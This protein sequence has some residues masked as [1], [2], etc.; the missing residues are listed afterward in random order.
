MG[1]SPAKWIKTVLFGKKSSKPNISKGRE[2]ISNE[3]EVVV[4]ARAA[5]TEFV[6]DPPA[7]FHESTNTTDYNKGL[8]L[9]NKEAPSVLGNGEP[10][11]QSTDSQGSTP[12]N[13]AYDPEKIRQEQAATKAQAAFRGYLARRAFWA[14]KGIIRLQALIRGHLVRRQ[15]V[16]TLCSML[17]I[18]KL[19]ALS[20]GRQVRQSI[21]GLE[22]Q[23]RCHVTPLE[24][25]LVDPVRVNI[26][27][28]MA[29]L[30]VNVFISKLLAFSPT[31]MPLRLHYEPG[32]P[33]SVP[34]WLERWSATHFW[35]PLPQPR[36]VPD[37]KSQRTH[38]DPQTGRVKRSTR[39]LPAANV[40]SVSVQVTS[41][42]EK[43][44]RILRKVSSQPADPVQENPQIELEKVKRNLRKVHTPIVENSVQTEIEAQNLTQNLEKASSSV[45]GHNV[46][47]GIT[48][49][50]VEKMKNEPIVALFNLPDAEITPEPSAAKEVFNLLSDDQVAMD[51]KTLTEGTGEEINTPSDEAAVES[52]ILTESSKKDENIPVPNVVL[53]QGEDLT[54]NDNQKSSRKTS[55]PAKQER[56]ENGL[57]NSPTLPSYMAATESAK[58]KLR[59]QGSPRLG[60][61]A[62]EK[63]EKT[64]STRRHSLPSSA[65]GKITSQS[66]RTQKP[67]Q[68]GGKGGIKSDKS[69]SASRD[70]KASQA[71]W[72]R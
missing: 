1:K 4:A 11:S 64:N 15:A 51:S 3:K 8:E 23:K 53:S 6:A 37:S 50:S 44:K 17:G 26:S 61:E 2:R 29:K 5:A 13:A 65:N 25:R 21:I 32:D 39:R 47:E 63:T 68:S 43:P 59:A 16:A 56:S 57:Q 30:T 34:N 67:V 28:Q 7:A 12:Q 49:N 69:L 60:L 42:S 66:P 20:R 38:R 33:N 35:K 54:S 14:L 41:E 36:K 19:Q 71:E 58:A 24:G 46:F 55:T 9:E 22:V 40:E 31:V 62:T 45:S 18:V 27:T 72:R 48:N 70:G 10:G 52:N